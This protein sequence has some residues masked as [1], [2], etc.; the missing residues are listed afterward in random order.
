MLFKTTLIPL[1]SMLVATAV[2]GAQV[3]VWFTAEAGSPYDD[4][5]GHTL[6]KKMLAFDLDVNNQVAAGVSFPVQYWKKPGELITT[7]VSPLTDS[8]QSNPVVG[9]LG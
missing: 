5:K 4:G 3:H 1:L 2:Q 7:T 8:S 6:L 9:F